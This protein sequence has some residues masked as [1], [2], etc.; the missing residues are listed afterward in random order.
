LAEAKSFAREEKNNLSD[1]IKQQQNKICF[2]FFHLRDEKIKLKKREIQKQLKRSSSGKKWRKNMAFLL[3]DK[4]H[5]VA[6]Y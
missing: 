1:D 2:S 4:D 3:A 6:F 5:I